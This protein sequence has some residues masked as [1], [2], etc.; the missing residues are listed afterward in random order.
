ML[1]A[2]ALMVAGCS[3]DTPPTPTPAP[4]AS[5]TPMSREEAYAAVPLDGTA[6]TPITWD[7]TAVKESTKVLA[8]R[9]GLAHLYWQWGATDWTPIIPV[10]EALYLHVF[11]EQSWEPFAGVTDFTEPVNGPLR[12]KAMGEDKTSEGFPVVT[13]CTDRS[14]WGDSGDRPVLETYLIH[15]DARLGSYFVADEDA[16]AKYRTQCT[17]WAGR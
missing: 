10:A 17:E 12:V 4:A 11:Y 13:F 16:E 15:S 6:D 2:T 8:A 7:L 5:P 9:H 14:R 3:P 1:V